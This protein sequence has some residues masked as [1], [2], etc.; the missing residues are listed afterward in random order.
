M[1]VQNLSPTNKS[2]RY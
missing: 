1:T 2:A